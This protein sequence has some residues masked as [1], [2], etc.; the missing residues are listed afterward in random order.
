MDKKTMT[1]IRNAS[2]RDFL[3]AYELRKKLAQADV[4]DVVVETTPEEDAA[5][6]EECARLVRPFDGDIAVGQ[7]RVLSGVKEITYALVAQKWDERSWL[8]IPFSSFSVPATDTEL[9]MK[10]DG[11]L[12]LRVVQLW[13]ARSLLTET[14]AKSW[15][16]HTLSDEDAADV[17]SAWQWSVGNGE[18]SNDQQAR[19]GMPIMRRDDPRIAYEDEAL[20]NFAELDAAD[21]AANERQFMADLVRQTIG[22]NRWRAFRPSPVFEKDYALAAASV[23]KP[24]SAN[25]NVD[26]LD[27]TV[28]VHYSPADGHLMLRVFG[29]DGARSK[30]LDGWGVFGQDATLFGTIEDA[31]FACE[32]K[33]G[34]DGALVLVDEEG[35]LHPLQDGAE[36]TQG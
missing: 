6:R 1:E 9:K 5:A 25:C 14:V 2:T 29:S 16:V 15:L 17:V 4:D 19:T 23:A 30:A 7:V 13:N 34:F 3:V 28:Y 8:V 32:F 26:G 27:G 20:A 35:A 11:G 12:G 22:G 33:D 21:F 31:T 18:L 24:V 36:A 10:V